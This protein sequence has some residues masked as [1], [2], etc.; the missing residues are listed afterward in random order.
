M[1]YSLSSETRGVKH[2][3]GFRGENLVPLLFAFRASFCEIETTLI[4]TLHSS[5]PRNEHTRSTE[6]QLTY[7]IEE[8]AR[9]YHY[10][11][12]VFDESKGH[13][14]ARMK[15]VAAGNRGGA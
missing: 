10:P 9:P 6:G 7:L 12:R 11:V 5:Q 8:F 13:F 14:G 3:H 2:T 1:T 4:I 15:T